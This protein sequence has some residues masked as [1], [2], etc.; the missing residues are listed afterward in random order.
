MEISI[1]NKAGELL[2]NI[3]KIDDEYS[4]IEYNLQLNPDINY[5]ALFLSLLETPYN[6][7]ESFFVKSYEDKLAILRMNQGGSGFSGLLDVVINTN[8]LYGSFTEEFN[9]EYFEMYLYS[10]INRFVILDSI[11]EIEKK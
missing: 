3:R 2:L 7:R 4:E 5:E 11:V 8:N 9:R 1:K 10:F 6:G